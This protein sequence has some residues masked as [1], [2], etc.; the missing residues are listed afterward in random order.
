M[1]G[2]AQQ[3]ERRAVAPDT[4]V[5]VPSHRPKGGNMFE[6]NE[7]LRVLTTH[8]KRLHEALDHWLSDCEHH[9]NERFAEGQ[10]GYIGRL[11]VRMYIT[12]DEFDERVE[13]SFELSL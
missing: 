8:K 13:A 11:V 3:A 9:G 5:R 4:R 7:R 6:Q 1:A 12:D 10:M 2:V